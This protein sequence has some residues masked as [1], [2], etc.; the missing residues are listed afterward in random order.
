MGYN[1]KVLDKITVIGQRANERKALW[2]TISDRFKEE[3]AEG[4][5]NE[6]ARQMDEI[7]EKFDALLAKLN[8]VL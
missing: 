2:Y 7:R 1:E 4:V 8:D 3:G 5:A 6:L